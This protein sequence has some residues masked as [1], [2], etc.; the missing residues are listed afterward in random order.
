M[1][2]N[3]GSNA[4]RY[5]LP[6]ITK[7]QVLVGESKRRWRR[8]L[9]YIFAYFVKPTHN[10]HNTSAYKQYNKKGCVQTFSTIP[11]LVGG[12]TSIQSKRCFSNRFKKGG[13]SRWYASSGSTTTTTLKLLLTTHDSLWRP[14][15]MRVYSCVPIW[16]QLSKRKQ[17]S[18]T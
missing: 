8:I 3:A 4:G 16:N 7:E 1:G 15:A 5:V 10:L 6:M 12:R 11:L 13:A 2:L 18:R 14:I 9:I 17:K